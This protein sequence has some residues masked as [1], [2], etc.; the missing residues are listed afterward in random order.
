MSSNLSIAQQ[1]IKSGMRSYPNEV[2]RSKGGRR[3]IAQDF[4]NQGRLRGIPQHYRDYYSQ[5]KLGPTQHIHSQPNTATFEKVTLQLNKLYSCLFLILLVFQ[6][7][8]GEIYPVQN[9]RI[10]VVYPDQF[11]QGL[12]GGEG[13]IK[14]MLKRADGNHR[15][16]TPP[17]AKYWWPRLFEGVVHSEVLG[18]HIEVVCT[19][20]GI[21]LVDEAG[22]FDHYL[23]K[24]PVNE[25]YATGMLR[26]KR[27]ILLSLSDREQFT[28][29]SGG[30]P[31]VF[32]KYAQ[33]AVS[34]EEADWHGLTF[35]EA[36]RKQ[37]K[38]E[39]KRE[40]E[41]VVPDKLK[42]RRE[43]I[44]LL[45]SGRADD[46]EMA[47]LESESSEDKSWFSNKVSGFKDL[48]K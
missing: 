10:Y 23:L 35:G 1:I 14:G 15:N 16:F 9:P 33:Y 7:E 3:V 36:L 42:Y 8:W 43:L 25:V 26:I 44:D 28:R 27:E 46:L 45:K 17:A 39:M 34:H 21:K 48:M 6:D 31:E 38:I 4:W 47:E 2:L 41:S 37:A 24:T 20:R 5:W 32:D 19:K 40:E 13:V 22:G 18:A 29:R 30:K 12:W 11:H